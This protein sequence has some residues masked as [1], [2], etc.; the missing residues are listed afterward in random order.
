MFSYRSKVKLRLD[1][2]NAPVFIMN[3]NDNLLKRSTEDE[4]IN[5]IKKKIMRHVSHKSEEI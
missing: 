3:V 5:Y 2:K 1:Y 4:F